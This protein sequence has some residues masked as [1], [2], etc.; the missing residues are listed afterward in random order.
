[1][2]ETP[3][4]PETARASAGP[5]PQARDLIKRRRRRGPGRAGR[6]PL[7]V[8][9]RLKTRV[10]HVVDTRSVGLAAWLLRSTQGRIVRPWRRQVLILT[11]RGRRSGRAR[12]VPLQYFPDGEAMIVVAANSGLPTPPGWYFNLTAHPHV[13]VE[14][15]G[16]KL[17]MRAEELS[18]DQA[19]AFWPRLRQVPE[20]DQPPHPA[21]PARSHRL[22]P[23]ERVERSS[24]RTTCSGHGPPTLRAARRGAP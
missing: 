10:E 12:A 11:T 19:A 17:Q 2:P 9:E 15:L 8:S 13:D 4:Q 18:A 20:E 7:R 21:D 6:S 16:R 22:S 24:L 23:L 3:R 5:A 1:M 14:V